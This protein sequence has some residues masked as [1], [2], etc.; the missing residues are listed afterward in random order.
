M[1]RRTRECVQRWLVVLVCACWLLPVPAVVR[2]ES[3]SPAPP[4]PED[5]VYVYD[6][7]R[8]TPG[9]PELVERLGSR[10]LRSTVILSVEQGPD[11]L[12]D[13][14]EGEALLACALRKLQED[15][16]RAKA[17]FLQAPRFLKDP[18]EA[19]RRAALLGDFSSRY[20]GLIAGVQVNIEPY[21]TKDWSNAG[22]AGRRRI[23]ADLASLLAE[24]REPLLGLPLGL[25]VSWWYPAVA[26]ELPEAAPSAW[27][28]VTDEV[29]VMAYGDMGGPLVG[30]SAQRVLERVDPD[31][32]F[33]GPG[34]VHLA[35]AAHEF[36]SPQ[37]LDGELASLRRRLTA[38]PGFAGTAVFHAASPYDVPLVRI[39]AGAIKDQR[40]RRL[41]GVTVRAGKLRARTDESGQFYLRGLRGSHV[42]L[43]ISRPGFGTRRMKV[44]LAQPGREL[45]LGKITLRQAPTQV[46]GAGLPGAE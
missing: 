9:C 10:P 29:Y 16:R 37:H 46:S 8:G 6:V 7:F 1:E 21:V 23:L 45:D 12:L 15:S 19:V 42:E 22:R 11:F 43:V 3:P 13:R 28:R 41:A 20:P 18:R 34:R 4:R 30:G 2:A 40:N 24:L 38:Y 35:V 5:A 32:F 14:P 44:A 39:V 31:S 36:R 25:A 33:S 27:L 26:G 17:L